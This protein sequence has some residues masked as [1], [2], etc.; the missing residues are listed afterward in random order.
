MN[1]EKDPRSKTRIV[2]SEIEV[3]SWT[4]DR[5][6]CGAARPSSCVACGAASRVPGEALVIVG[7]GLRSRS[8]E[9]PSAPGEDPVAIELLARR[10]ACRACDAILVVLPR[11]V[12]RGTR[13]SLSAIAHALALWGYARWSAAK[14][15]VAISAAR[16]RGFTSPEQWSS[17]RRWTACAT[18]LFG[19]PTTTGS[20][21]ERA[22]Q[23]AAW[24]ASHAPLAIGVVPTD[25]F[26]GAPFVRTR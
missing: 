13:Y 22:S 10:Y 7:H 5:A 20:L 17:L 2:H 8:V 12:G 23:I 26:F 18:A 21:R 15:R 16:A 19:A 11:G 24:L 1:L 3:K 9:G 14:T 25:A 6:S 4:T